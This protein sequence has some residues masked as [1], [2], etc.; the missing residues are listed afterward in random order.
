MKHPLRSSRVSL[1]KNDESGEFRVDVDGLTKGMIIRGAI[2]Y[3]SGRWWWSRIDYSH[4]EAR[5][6]EG[7]VCAVLGEPQP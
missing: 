3:G 5:T 4:G 6:K 7:A 1:V 2:G